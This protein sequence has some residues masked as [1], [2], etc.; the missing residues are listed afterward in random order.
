MIRQNKDGK[1][2]F[3]DKVWNQIL[4]Y[5]KMLEKLGYEESK[6][7]PNLFYKN[8]TLKDEKIGI[9]FVDLRGTDYI[10]IW[11]R[12]YPI[13]YHNEYLKF[14]DFIKEV[15]RLKRLGI[16]IRL[17]FFDK[18][19]PEGWAFFLKEIPIGICKRCGKDIIEEVDWT[20]L[21]NG[22]YNSKLQNNSI[23]INNSKLL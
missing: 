22:A 14:I 4:E 16:D 2:I 1:P 10:P 19:E 23:D 11:E 8:L 18:F 21:E 7:S 15:V 17:S 12:P 6:K 20:V 3:S 13:V 5:G 9:I